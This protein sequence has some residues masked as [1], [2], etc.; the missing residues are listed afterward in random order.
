MKKHDVRRPLLE[1]LR[2]RAKEL[3]CLYR[4]EDV[5]RRGEEPL[6][7]LLAGVADVLP[8][9][10]QLPEIC[11]A[12]IIF[13][14]LTVETEGYREPL[15]AMEE[16]I[17]AG[18]GPP[19]GSVEV[20]YRESTPPGRDFPFLPEERTLLRTIAHRVGQAI[21][22]RRLAAATNGTANGLQPGRDDAR[23]RT[24]IEML[25]ATDHDLY[26][27]VLR[28]M[29][30]H[31]CYVGV[32]RAG[33]IL[34][35]VSEAGVAADE[36]S[37]VNRPQQRVRGYGIEDVAGEVLDLGAEHLSEEVVLE[38]LRKW[39]A[40]GKLSTLVEVVEDR[41]AG[42]AETISAIA[43]LQEEGVETVGL[44]PSVGRAVNVSLIRRF[45]SGR[46]EFINL[47]KNLVSI[48][49]FQM[50]SAS[51][52]HPAKSH[53]YLG[54]KSAGLF[55]ARK[56]V[57]SAQEKHP[58]LRDMRVPKT[59]HVVS[60][61]LTAFIHHNRLEE[62]LEHKYRDIGHIR[63]E[64]PNLVTLFKSC[65]FP[66]EIVAGVR[67]AMDDLGG[68]PLVVRSSSLLEDSVGA[69]FAGKYKS[70][71]V[72]NQ[73]TRQE[74]LEALLDAIAEV[75][76]SM[77]APDPIQYRTERGLLDFPEEMGVLL[78]EVV[79]TRVGHYWLPSFAGVAFSR[80]EFR[81]SP[82]IRREDGLVRLVPG[83]GTRAV[84]RTGDD[85][86]VL[87][88]P[89]QPG[90]KVNI[91]VDDT[92]RYSPR[93]ADVINLETNDIETV[94]LQSLLHK[95]GDEYPCLRDIFSVVKD[96]MVVPAGGLVDFEQDFLVA[97]MDGLLAKTGF[98][99]R[100]GTLLAVLERHYGAPVDLEFAGDGK[101]FHLLQCR[102]Q[103]S[104]HDLAQ[105]EMPTNLSP[106]KIV[107]TANRYVSDGY[108]PNITHVV[109]VVPAAYQELSD[110]QTLREVGATVGALNQVLPTRGFVLI[111]PGRWGSRGD[112]K[113]GVSVG[114]SDICNTAALMEVA[115]RRG[116]Y[117]PD[118]SFGTHFFQ[119]LVE[120]SIAYLPLYP[121]E[122]GV[123]FNEQFLRHSPNVL[124]AYV[125]GAHALEEVVRVVDV[126]ACCDG[127]LLHLVMNSD[128]S[129]AIAFLGPATQEAD[130]QKPSPRRILPLSSRAEDHWR[131]RHRM[132]DTIAAGIDASQMGVQA[133]YLFGSVKNATAG[134]ASDIDLIIHIRGD[135]EQ[136]A[137]LEAWLGGWSA[138]LAEMN[139]LR[140][141]HR[142]EGLLDVHYVTD[143][144]I[145]GKTSYAARIGA[146]SDGAR[147]LN[148]GK[149]QP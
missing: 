64:Y 4:V 46:L 119:D 92:I 114:Y 134:P 29:L 112:I 32:V 33:K 113:L 84:D 107:L 7:T 138:S 97:T 73:G 54:G 94:S 141:G 140:T 95:H 137:L 147:P 21:L 56:V 122:R 66:R 63:L 47:A 74:R 76:A 98:L 49:D 36:H 71:F 88:A 80:N 60:D 26:V 51:L 39:I 19:A 100:M 99:K 53:G 79:G 132:A 105:E 58:E 78:Q 86:P 18:E 87:A 85:Y 31:L 120:A 13:E 115:F 90:L 131:W 136:R 48:K 42:L 37:G 124:T 59:W 126:H 81:W 146:V 129:K 144:D 104:R 12:R 72:G 62:F 40:E 102:V 130:R 106:E 25:R 15:C 17:H 50:L 43:R 61:A 135:R 133:I 118:L 9:G 91:S 20:S 23:W 128:D 52:V 8:D 149:H 101:D 96:G 70:L 1:A 65:S 10:W 22:H 6:D 16:P 77:F 145:A 111:G 143:E 34:S 3:S 117:V 5:L 139:F 93:H 41:S 57:E 110:L 83:L 68:G 14:G 125:P 127:A 24:A 121:G 148:L 89:G 11:Q 123:V 2:E 28:R 103:S 30:N 82:R 35:A 108:V 75:Y 69:A 27:Q 116:D 38:Y 67:S 55:V 142:S 45:F 44:S 109:Y